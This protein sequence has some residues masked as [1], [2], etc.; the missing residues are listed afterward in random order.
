MYFLCHLYARA[1]QP[2]KLV[3]YFGIGHTEYNTISLQLD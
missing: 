3:W 2:S 1:V